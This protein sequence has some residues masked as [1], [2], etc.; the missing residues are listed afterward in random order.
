MEFHHS[1][2]VP[3]MQN[4]SAKVLEAEQANVS[5]GLLATPQG[6]HGICHQ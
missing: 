4:M 3:C 5:T 2:T 6:L 1:F